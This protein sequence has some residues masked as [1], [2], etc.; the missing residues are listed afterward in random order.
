MS[1]VLVSG[2]SRGLTPAWRFERLVVRATAPELAAPTT[3]LPPR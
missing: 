2:T 1:V 3:L